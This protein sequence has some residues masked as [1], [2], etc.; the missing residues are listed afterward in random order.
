VGGKD[1]ANKAT[2]KLCRTTHGMAGHLPSMSE[3]LGSIPS[4]K[5]NYLINKLIIIKQLLHA[6]IFFLFR[7]SFF[8]SSYFIPSMF[9]F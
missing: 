8:L 2:R 9:F 1:T 6:F 5:I 7:T 4:L 3:V